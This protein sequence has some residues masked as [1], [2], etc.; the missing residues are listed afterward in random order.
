MGVLLK[1]FNDLMQAILSCKKLDYLILIQRFA[2][3]IMR[4]ILI[5]AKYH[6]F[7]FL[8]LS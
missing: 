1:Q 7:K 5:L 3:L 6:V 4:E 8:E 2:S